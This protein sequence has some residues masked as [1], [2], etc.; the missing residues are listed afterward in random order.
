MT[1]DQ[2]KTLIQ[3]AVNEEILTEVL[4]NLGSLNS[5]ISSSTLIGKCWIEMINNLA[6]VIDEVE[7]FRYMYSQSL[8]GPSPNTLESMRKLQTI[9]QLLN[10]IKPIILGMDDIQKKDV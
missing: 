2:I 7:E 4:T 8:H 10:E 9:I 1:K 5:G 3:E 6:S